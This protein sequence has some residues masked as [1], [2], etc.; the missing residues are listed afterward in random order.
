MRARKVS[1]VLFNTEEETIPW[2]AYDQEDFLMANWLPSTRTT[3][4]LEDLQTDGL[5]PPCGLVI[6]RA[7]KGKKQ[8][9]PHIDELISFAPFIERGLSQSIHPFLCGLLHF[10]GIKL[11]NLILNGILH[12][13][14]FVIFC[15]C[16]LGIR[17]HFNLWKTLFL[18]NPYPKREK[19]S[20]YRGARIQML[21]D[22]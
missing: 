8:P 14:V 3:A 6:R 5:L 12:V 9:S 22:V 20:I 4:H 13:T 10:Y 15:E 17:P 11:H 16:Y 1:D 21:P 7:A 18:M 19:T 2:E